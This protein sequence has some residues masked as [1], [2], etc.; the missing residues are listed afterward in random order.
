MMSYFHVWHY[1]V[2]GERVG[3]GLSSK[4]LMPLPAK[5]EIIRGKHTELVFDELL[6]PLQFIEL[7]LELDV[8]TH[9]KAH[10]E[11]GDTL[12]LLEGPL[13]HFIQLLFDFRTF[14]IDFFQFVFS[15][16][17]LFVQD[18]LLGIESGIYFF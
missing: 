4:H 1:F 11:L 18:F 7:S 15:V 10:L 3:D 16:G 14:A 6:H 9:Q 12:K 5:Q 8:V 17:H 2:G 13:H